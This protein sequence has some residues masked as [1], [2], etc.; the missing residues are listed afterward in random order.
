M[1]LHLLK[2]KLSLWNLKRKAR[3][4]YYTIED[5]TDLGCGISIAQYIRP[6]LAAKLQKFEALLIQAR[7]VEAQIKELEELTNG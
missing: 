1:K 4:L 7:A 5:E 3:N 6:Q 2:L